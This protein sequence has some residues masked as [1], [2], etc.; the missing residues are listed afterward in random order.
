M[1]YFS[2]GVTR[3]LRGMPFRAAACTGALYHIDLYL[4]CGELPGL[5]A[6][7][8]HYGPQDD[9]L[10]LLRPGEFR[11]TL[12]EA[13]G[14]QEWVARAPVSIVYT[15]TYWRNAWKY[16]ERAYRHAFWDS[17]TI[18]ANTLALAAAHGL[19]SGV[20]MGF[21]DRSVNRLLDLDAQK[22]VA[23]LVAPLGHTPDQMLPP[24]PPIAPLNLRTARYSFAEVEY[25]AIRA[26][27]AASSLSSANEVRTWRQAR[28]A[29]PV[30]GSARTAAMTPLRPLAL[31]VVS[32]SIEAV[33]RSRGSTRRFERTP[34]S[35]DALSTILAS[36][37]RR[38]EADY[39]TEPGTPLAECFLLV[40]AVEGLEPGAYRYRPG[41]DKLELLDAGERRDV[42]G[43]LAL[44]QELGA[45][46]A[47]NVY[48]LAHLPSILEALGNRGYRAAQLDASV[49]AGKMYL[50]AYAL[51]LGAT[52]LTFYDDEVTHFFGRPAADRSPMF[53]LALGNPALQREC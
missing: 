9:A 50:A 25:P 16:Q 6:G 18:L 11:G 42:A 20:V 4:V 3:V 52:G 36:A 33:I 48:F 38:F 40:N 43:H 5:A 30:D 28:P 14:G 13:C 53:L 2:N 10:R 31:D 49:M 44:D 39:R 21:V 7:V 35:C 41:G 23:L 51:G 15:T 12:I 26:M 29:A 27:H 47:V 34:I 22:E 37:T 1:C 24:A 32:D 17:G 19:P 46:A 45:D 8:Y